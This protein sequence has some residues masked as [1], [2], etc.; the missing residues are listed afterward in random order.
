FLNGRSGSYKSFVL[1]IFAV[2]LAT[3]R[4]VMGHRE[5]EVARPVKVLYVAAE[6]SAGVALRMR[7]YARRH[8]IREAPNLTL[9]PRAVNLTSPREMAD[10]E[11][12]VAEGGYEFLLVDTFRQATLG[13]N[14][15]DNSELSVVIGQMIALRDKYGCSTLFADHTGHAGERA[16]GGEAKWANSDYALMIKMPNG[17]RAADQQR[18]HRPPAVAH[19][20]LLRSLRL[21]ER[22]AKFNRLKVRVIPKPMTA[23][24]RLHDHSLNPALPHQLHTTPHHSRSTYERRT[25]VLLT[26]EALQQHIIV[27]RIQLAPTQVCAT[28]EPLAPHTRLSAE[29][30]DREAGIIRQCRKPA[31]LVKPACLKQCIP[32]KGLRHLQA[33]L[34]RILEDAGFVQ[35]HRLE[36]RSAQHWLELPQLAGIA[37]SHEQPGVGRIALAARPGTSAW[38][39]RHAALTHQPRTR[40]GRER[41]AAIICRP[42]IPA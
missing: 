20:L 6:G 38:R 39:L 18:T 16:V 9:Y 42:R 21:R 19:P 11:H 8:G 23:V 34:C 3:G 17:S 24:T 25:P 41:A 28:T 5:F 31:A 12:V 15:S 10:L 35:P 27:R 22:H 4:P 37:R 26:P 2:S 14:E 29:R 40:A 1:P 30:P 13:I 7:A 36:S 33:V 32:R